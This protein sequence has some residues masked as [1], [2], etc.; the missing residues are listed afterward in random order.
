MTPELEQRVAREVIEPALRG[1]ADRGAPFCGALFA[2]LMIEPDGTPQ[3]L[4]Y[5]VRLGDPET[6]VLME[7]I[8]GDLGEIL[9]AAAIGQLDP[10]RPCGVRRSTPSPWCWRPR[11]IREHRGVETRSRGSSRPRPCPG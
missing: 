8:E 11:A 7:L 6:E 2:G 4:E 10:L 1:L 5:N 9:Y 3:V